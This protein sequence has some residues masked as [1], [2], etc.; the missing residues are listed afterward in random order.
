MFWERLFYWTGF[1]FWVLF[2][3]TLLLAAYFSIRSWMEDIAEE[4]KPSLVI[5]DG[6]IFEAN[7]VHADTGLS[8]VGGEKT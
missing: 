5:K 3:A 2:L 4:K 1:I 6:D 7:E 8:N